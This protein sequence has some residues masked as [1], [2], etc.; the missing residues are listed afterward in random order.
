MPM[1]MAR[2]ASTVGSRESGGMGMKEPTAIRV[3][4]TAAT[5]AGTRKP[6]KAK[7]MIIG[8]T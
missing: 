2:L 8:M 3:A 5:S 7:V 6:S 4:A 1:E